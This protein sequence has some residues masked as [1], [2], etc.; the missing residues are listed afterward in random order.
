MSIT[1]TFTPWRRFRARKDHAAI[2]RWLES[3]GEASVRAF[4][5]GAS[6]QWPGGDAPGSSPGEWPM[7]RTGSL[8]ASI[9]YEMG[10]DEVTVGSNMYYSRYLREGTLPM[11]GR[12]KMSDDALEEGM[13]HARLGRWV[14]WVHS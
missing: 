11:G 6:R 4:R 1:I 10:G 7:K 8:L 9:K 3:V 5:E 2:R 13:K 12:R 14:E